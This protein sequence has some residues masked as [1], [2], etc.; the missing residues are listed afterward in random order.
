VVR[1]DHAAPDTMV[2][3]PG[4]AGAARVDQHRRTGRQREGRERR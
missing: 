2:V 3:I 1:T 4:D